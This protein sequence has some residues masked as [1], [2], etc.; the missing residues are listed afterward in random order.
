M[1]HSVAARH[2]LTPSDHPRAPDSTHVRTIRRF[3]SYVGDTSAP[4]Y[5]DGT[6][7]RVDDLAT[8]PYVWE[9]SRTLP[10]PL[11]FSLTPKYQTPDNPRFGVLRY[12][13]TRIDVSYME[14]QRMIYRAPRT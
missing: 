13:P 14:W 8:R 1:P 11:R 12:K 4:V 5:V 10:E 7:T 3:L 6:V 9:Y 2:P